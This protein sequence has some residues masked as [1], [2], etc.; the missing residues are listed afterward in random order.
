MYFGKSQTSSYHTRVFRLKKG[1]GVGLPSQGDSGI[2]GMGG[3][4]GSLPADNVGR[5]RGRGTKPIITL[6]PPITSNLL[7]QNN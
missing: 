4:S 2:R 3:G 7:L 1:R 5:G 6:A